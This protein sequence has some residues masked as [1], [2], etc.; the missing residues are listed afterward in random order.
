MGILAGEVFDGVGADAGRFFPVS[1]QRMAGQVQAADLFF[2]LS[3]SVW[4][5]S[6][7]LADL[8][9]VL[10]A[11]SAASPLITEN[12]SSWP[13]R[14]RRVSVSMLLRMPSTASTMLWRLM[15]NGQR[16]RL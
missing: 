7:K 13:S 15:P 3:S 4:L 10:L 2:L 11:A 16:H 6:G 1:V 5:Y 14:L 8:I 12:R 9:A